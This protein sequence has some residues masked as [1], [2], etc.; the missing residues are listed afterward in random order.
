MTL[1][2]GETKMRKSLL[3]V[4]ISILSLSANA[5]IGSVTAA[6]GDAGR[7][8]VEASETPFMNPAAIVYLKGYFFTMSYGSASQGTAGAQGMALSITENMKETVVPT[9]LAY[10]QVAIKDSAGQMTYTKDFR[11]SLGNFIRRHAAM[12]I[13]IHH[14]NDEL[15]GDRYAQTNVDLGL[16]WAPTDSIGFAGVFNTLIPPSGKVPEAYRLNQTSSFGAVYN[17]KKFVRIKADIVSSTNNSF[18]KPTLGA[19][20]ESYLNK[21]MIL[22]W[23]LAKNHELDANM[24]TAGVGWVLPR[25]GIHYAYQ[26]SPQDE[27]LTRHSVDLA[28]PV[29]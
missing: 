11:L 2:L 4:A 5:Y 18:N 23:G 14:K 13:G 15:P 24:Y 8:A 21:W 26:N 27:T 6:T 1:P 19:G 22:R 29:W 3:F 12:G 9:S 16:L 20:M 28:I 7:A 25:F 17:F 10:E